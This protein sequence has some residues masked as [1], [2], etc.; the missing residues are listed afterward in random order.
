MRSKRRKKTVLVRS[1]VEETG[2][3]VRAGLEKRCSS[4]Q[5]FRQRHTIKRLCLQIPACYIRILHIPKKCSSGSNTPFGFLKSHISFPLIPSLPPDLEGASHLHHP[6]CKCENSHMQKKS[7]ARSLR[8]NP[9]SACNNMT[10][11]ACPEEK[12]RRDLM[13]SLDA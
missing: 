5:I 7:L 1:W 6:K 13:Q 11:F 4:N 8:F 12:I 9:F 10:W 3:W 2:Q